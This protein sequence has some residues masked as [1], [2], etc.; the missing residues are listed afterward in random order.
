MR[1]ELF[2]RDDA[3]VQ[4]PFQFCE[5]F[6]RGLL[7]HD[8]HGGRTLTRGAHL[9]ADKIRYLLGR[10]VVEER[11]VERKA[12]FTVEI[13]FRVRICRFELDIPGNDRS[14]LFELQAD[15]GIVINLFD[16]AEKVRGRRIREGFW[17]CRRRA[18]R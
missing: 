7:L 14:R 1:V 10:R 8:L 6:R 4:K 15:H 5:L 18:Y 9:A 12:V 17:S 16:P 13:V 11:S 2:L 3:R